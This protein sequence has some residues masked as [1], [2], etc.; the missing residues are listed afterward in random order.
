[1]S[2]KVEDK[3]EEQ[4]AEFAKANKWDENSF[5]KLDLLLNQEFENG[6]RKA[7]RAGVLSYNRVMNPDSS[8][9]TEWIDMFN[10]PALNPE[11]TLIYKEEQEE[12]QK[13]DSEKVALLNKKLEA[14]SEL[15]KDIL[16]GIWVDKK[17]QKDLAEELGVSTRTIRRHC[18]SLETFINSLK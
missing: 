1:M 7:K 11:E 10:T 12:K 8:E 18:K 6:E 5:H 15:K 2:N 3:R 16:F 17:K 14:L 4:I 9:P 13:N